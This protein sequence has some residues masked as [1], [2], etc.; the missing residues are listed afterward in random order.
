M[1]RNK[2]R[3]NAAALHH[4]IGLEANLRGVVDLVTMESIYFEGNQG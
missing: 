1:E 3:L 4:P 2:L